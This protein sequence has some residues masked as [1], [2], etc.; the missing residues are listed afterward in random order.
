MR[1]SKFLMFAFAL[2]S[3]LL[4]GCDLFLQGAPVDRSPRISLSTSSVSFDLATEE[5]TY[6]INAVVENQIEG[7]TYNLGFVSLNDVVASC[8]NTGLVTAN[9]VGST[10]VKVSVTNKAA[11]KPIFFNISVINTQGPELQIS[12]TSTFVKKGTTKQ[13][14]AGVKRTI[15]TISWSSSNE[16]IATVNDGLVTVSA[17]ATANTHFTITA[18]LDVDSTIKASCDFTVVDYDYTIMAYMCGS[19]LEYDP[20][21][22]KTVDKEV[23]LISDD[24]REI[25]SIKNIPDGVKIIIE[26]GGVTNK[27]MMESNFLYGATSISTSKL[28]RWEVKK[29]T[30]PY[31]DN[32]VTYYNK[33]NLI[34]TLNTNYMADQTSFQSFVSWGLTNYSA[35]QMGIFLSGHGGG[36]AGCLYDDNYVSF[37]EN[38]LDT[39]EIYN[40]TLSALNSVNRDKMTWIGFDCCLM[41]C[42]D[43]ASKMAG[44]FEYMVASQE[45]EDGYGWDHDVWMEK[46]I[47]NVNVSPKVVF[48]S[49]TSSFI[50]F[51]ETYFCGATYQGSTYYCYQTLAAYDLSKVDIL[52]E[53]FESLVTSIGS[54]YSKYKNA[55]VASSTYTYFG[56]G[57]YGLADF[58]TFL[59]TLH[60]QQRCD[61]SKV[62]AAINDVVIS[63]S[64]C[65]NYQSL[66][67]APCGLN[68]FMPIAIDNT[69]GL[70]VPKS[71]YTGVDQTAFSKWQKICLDN[72]PR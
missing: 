44:C 68:V 49:I 27:W 51:N 61:V 3:L 29:V 20:S 8:S 4:S 58:N 10:Q 42:A 28:Q 36:I 37:Y 41:G 43:I 13:L 46:I 9:A 12:E 1:K 63:N 24:L 2:F 69:Y 52:V 60:N 62:K 55:F 7:Q 65:T 18:T 15:S 67:F 40:A 23:G 33:L 53:E 6:Q 5:R 50:D 59:D 45:S 35:K 72:W 48:D 56:E 30:T 21:K 16:S 47:K 66:G 64:Y 39:S 11:I 22:I 19:T 26:T 32:L 34:E 25:L 17:S 54:T 57:V 14:T 70:Q 71:D 38:T 31:T